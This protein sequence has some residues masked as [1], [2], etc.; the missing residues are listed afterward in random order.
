MPGYS[1]AHDKHYQWVEQC[2]KTICSPLG[3]EVANVLGFVGNGLY[4]SPIRVEKL[5]GLTIMIFVSFGL[6]ALLTGTTSS[7]QRC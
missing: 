2:T 4:N 3:K 5:T 1:Y 7:C 6:V